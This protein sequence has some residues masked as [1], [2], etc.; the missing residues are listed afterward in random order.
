MFHLDVPPLLPGHR[1]FD[2]LIFDLDGTLVD[3]HAVHRAALR[4]VFARRG[5]HV[6]AAAGAPEGIAFTDWV[7]RLM[8]RGHL[9]RALP[10]REL[11]QEC[12]REVLQRLASVTEVRPVVAMARWA[13]GRV[14]TAVTTSSSRG[15]AQAILLATGLRGLFDVLITREQ[16]MRGKPAPDLFLLASTVLGAIPAR[17]L[18][19]EDTESGLYAAGRAGMP[20]VDV[21]PHRSR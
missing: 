7:Q 9:P 2:A 12:Q 21:R 20:S 15:T 4:E 17:C 10:V 8:A 5:L 13:Q 1:S 19:F 11:H 6:P 18:V 16:V 14:P 3:S